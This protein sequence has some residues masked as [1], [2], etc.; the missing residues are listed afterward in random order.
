MTDDLIAFYIIWVIVNEIIGSLITVV[1]VTTK[2]LGWGRIDI[3]VNNIDDAGD[4]LNV[5]INKKANTASNDNQIDEWRTVSLSSYFV[6][7]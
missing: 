5:D 1:A 6:R 2:S 7:L 4:K 3:T